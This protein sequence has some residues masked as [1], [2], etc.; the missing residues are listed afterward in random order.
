VHGSSHVLTSNP[1]CIFW[2][3][4]LSSAVTKTPPP[5]EKVEIL[6]RKKGRAQNKTI[7]LSVRTPPPQTWGQVMWGSFL[8]GPQFLA[9]QHHSMF[10]LHP[11]SRKHRHIK[12]CSYRNATAQNPLNTCGG[13]RNAH[14]TSALQ[15]PCGCAAFYL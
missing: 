12:T 7:H 6:F 3:K 10:I 9:G 1:L 5:P 4:N 15:C 11:P 2:S 8:C 13:S 14:H